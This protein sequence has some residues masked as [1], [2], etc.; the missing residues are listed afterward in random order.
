MQKSFGLQHMGATYEQLNQK[1]ARASRAAVQGP[2]P[3]DFFQHFDT[4]QFTRHRKV[5]KRILV[6]SIRKYANASFRLAEQYFLANPCGS[7]MH[8]DS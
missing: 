1:G 3:G 8:N 4:C 5:N 7:V 6:Q 2:E